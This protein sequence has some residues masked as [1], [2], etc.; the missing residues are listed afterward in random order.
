VEILRTIQPLRVTPTTP[1][2]TTTTGT[3]IEPKTFSS[4]WY[5]C[6]RTLG[7]RM[8]GLYGTKDTFVTMALRVGAKI[9]WLEN[10]TGV[11]Y[12][13]LRRHYGKWMT[14]E[15]RTE[16]Q[17]F[18]GVDA[19]LLAE[20]GEQAESRAQDERRKFATVAPTLFEEPQEKGSDRYR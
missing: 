17:K 15:D 2:F 7:V 6:L 18:A 8:R 4:H 12:A 10:Q 16:Q 3:R 5:D 11:N 19:S 20:A 14:T 9:A 1:V 13:T